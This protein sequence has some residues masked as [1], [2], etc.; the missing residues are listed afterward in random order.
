MIILW[1]LLSTSSKLYAQVSMGDTLSP[2]VIGKVISI[3][4]VKKT[5]DS[6]WLND[7]EILVIDF[8]ATWCT[9]CISGFPALNETYH[10]FAGRG[11]DFIAVS[12]EKQGRVEHFLSSRN[13]DFPVGIDKEGELFKSLGITAI[14]KCVV[15]NK[16]GVVLY[17]GSHVDN[18]I[19]DKIL[20]GETPSVDTSFSA[21]KQLNG[22][23][24]ISDG[25]G[26]PGDDPVFN[27]MRLMMGQE[28]DGES[29]AL[30]QTIF[31]KSLQKTP[32]WY[33]ERNE[34]DLKGITLCGGLSE[35]LGYLLGATSEVWVTDNVTEGQIYDLVYWGKHRKSFP[36]LKR[37]LVRVIADAMN[38]RIDKRPVDTEFIKMKFSRKNPAMTYAKVVPQEERYDFI[39][40]FDVVSHLETTSGRKYV[41][42]EGNKEYFIHWPK[43]NLPLRQM[44]VENIEQW[45]ESLGVDFERTSG[46]V[47]GYEIVESRK[48]R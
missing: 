28:L 6:L 7:N 40:L 12:Q 35:I 43:D 22:N 47:V 10:K 38:I 11:V 8:W 19:L 33:G 18:E 17:E 21:P 1:I 4:I 44:S 48:P 27:G 36:K 3:Q 29:N 14:P 42:S 46:K 16:L 20:Q 15:I 32:G 41:F 45:L 37:G 30:S 26:S 2:D 25:G 39:S 34:G 13:Y 5:E 9:P 24:V 31:R 23:M